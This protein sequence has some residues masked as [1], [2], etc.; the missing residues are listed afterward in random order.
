MANLFDPQYKDKLANLL[1]PSQR[2]SKMQCCVKNSDGSRI[3]SDDLSAYSPLTPER[4][5]SGGS[6]NLNDD[7]CFLN[8][9]DKE[10]SQTTPESH[11]CRLL[12]IQG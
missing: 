4:S 1:T 7:F 12:W 3:P 8:H 5:S 6:S 11:G 2:E 10:H 9:R